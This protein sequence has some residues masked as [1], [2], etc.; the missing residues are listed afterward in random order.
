M[1]MRRTFTLVFALI[2]FSIYTVG[3]ANIFMGEITESWDSSNE[4][5][6]IRVERRAER[7]A[8]LLPGAYYV[9]QSAPVGSDSWKEIFTFRHD[10]PVPIPRERIRL[11][12]EQV[13]YAFMGWMYAVTIDGGKTWQ[14]WD[15]DKDMQNCECSNYGLIKD[16]RLVADGSGTMELNRVPLRIGKLPELYTTDYG[17]HWSF[18]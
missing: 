10:D 16:V 3:C 15:A 9:F 11:V 13:G 8:F 18:R 17:R 12:N 7:D 14:V 6:K 1:T 2:A 5:F 4:R